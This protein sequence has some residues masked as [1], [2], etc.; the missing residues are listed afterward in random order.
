MSK[1][2]V[3]FI[4]ADVWRLG[5]AQEGRVEVR[6]LD[7]DA[8]T[9]MADRIATVRANLDEWG[10]ADQAIALALDSSWCLSASIAT[11]ELERGARR[12]AMAYRLE[13][14]LPISAEDFVA[15]YVESDGE[16]LGVCC[17]TGPLREVIEGF[18]AAGISVR[19]AMP[20]ALLAAAEAIGHTNQAA[21]LVLLAEPAAQVA[22]TAERMDADDRQR[23]HTAT[24]YDL[25]EFRKAVPQRWW[26][27][28]DDE[29][30]V[31]DRLAAFAGSRDAPAHLIVLGEPSPQLNTTLDQQADIEPPTRLEMELYEAATHRA[32][33]VLAEQ[34][35][36]WIDLRTGS[37]AAPDRFEVYRKPATAL[38][39]ATV[40]LLIALIGVTQWRAHVY[41]QRV[42]AY[43]ADQRVVFEQAVDAK[44][45][46]DNLI[47]MRLRSERRSYA[48]L[49]GQ[50]AEDGDES[51]T[52]PESALLHLARVLEAM[53]EGLRW[54]ILELSIE[55]A[56]IRVDGQARSHIEA[57]K[58]AT[59]LR[60]AG[61]YQVEPPRTQT[62]REKGVSFVFTATPPDDEE[63]GGR[64]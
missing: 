26:W 54:R 25:L 49:A 4:T 62:L 41:D 60:Q 27:L 35:E 47:T 52:L 21:D 6:G 28:A 10:Y 1:Q 40:A 45:P 38:L 57:E 53:P 64:S 33:G 29:S 19:H 9:S 14:H 18:E 44:P 59:A 2:F 58:I 48:A 43:R 34:T 12:Q 36:P 50:H 61:H 63:R 31:G 3:V 7:V 17:E 32:A 30:A 11:D 13:E 5:V 20:T 56:L 42:A 37:L 22:T 39:V 8:S 24:R 51:F 16:A 15:D 23:T 46:S 55:P